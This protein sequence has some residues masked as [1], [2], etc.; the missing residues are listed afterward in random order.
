MTLQE[1]NYILGFLEISGLDNEIKEHEEQIKKDFS[2]LVATLPEK[3]K[4]HGIEIRKKLEDFI[5]ALKWHCIGI[6]ASADETRREWNMD[7]IPKILRVK[8]AGENDK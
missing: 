2:E 5:Y 8:G 3:E 7:F 1:K 6:G 4:A